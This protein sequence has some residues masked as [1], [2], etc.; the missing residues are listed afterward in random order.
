[1]AW[2]TR[3]SSHERPARWYRACGLRIL[4]A[5]ALPLDPLSEPG[6]VH[7]RKR[8]NPVAVVRAHRPFGIE[9]AHGR[10]MALAAYPLGRRHD[11]L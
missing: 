8:R 11:R 4:S 10:I 1:M 9:E 3:S 2:N 7:P 6:A 5:L